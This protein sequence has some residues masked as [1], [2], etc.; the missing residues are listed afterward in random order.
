MIF[1]Q[2][3]AQFLRLLP[4]GWGTSLLRRRTGKAF[5]S[6]VQ[7]IVISDSVASASLLNQLSMQHENLLFTQSFHL[8]STSYASLFCSIRR[9]EMLNTSSSDAVVSC[10]ALLK[11]MTRYLGMLFFRITAEPYSST[12]RATLEKF[13]FASEWKLSFVSISHLGTP[14]D[15]FYSIY[16]S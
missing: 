4:A 2:A 1:D 11:S 13:W 8:A 14:L 16:K 9:F 7:Q 12:R 6:G 10:S 5:E 3:I 15:F